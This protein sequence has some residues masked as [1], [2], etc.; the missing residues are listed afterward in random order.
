M[1]VGIALPLWAILAVVLYLL[2]RRGVI[3]GRAGLR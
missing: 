1:A 3:G 2:W